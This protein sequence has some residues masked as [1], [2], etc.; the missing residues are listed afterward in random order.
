[1]IANVTIITLA[2]FL[3]IAFT[4]LERLRF[5]APFRNSILAAHQEVIIGYLRAACSSTSSESCS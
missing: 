3:V 1:M 5:L 2:L 4:L